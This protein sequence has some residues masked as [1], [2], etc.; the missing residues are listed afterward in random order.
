MK[1]SQKRSISSWC[2]PKPRRSSA[3]VRS[4]CSSGDS[5]RSRTVTRAIRSRDD[6]GRCEYPRSRSPGRTNDA[7]AFSSITGSASGSRR[8]ASPLPIRSTKRSYS[9]KQ[10]SAMCWPLSGGGGGSPSRSGSVWTAPPSVGRASWRTTSWPA[11]ASSSAAARPAS[12]PPT[13]ATRLGAEAP[14][15][16][17]GASSGSPAAAG[18]R[19]RRSRAPRSARASPGR[20]R[21]TCPRTRSCD[22][23][24]SRAGSV[25]R[26]GTNEP[27][28]D[29]YAIS[30]CQAGVRRP[31]AMSSSAT[32][33]EASS[34]CG[35]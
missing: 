2:W 15:P 28:R 1:T 21:R 16:R 31:A 22:G 24:G 13:T 8:S 11:S 19:R 7:R 5:P 18:R 32:P 27:A 29:W 12:P 26:P 6:R 14:R 20:G 10:P 17:C 35:R 9:V 4:E 30:A 3:N 33:N 34:S 25:P 23:R